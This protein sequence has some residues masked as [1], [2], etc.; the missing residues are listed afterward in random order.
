MNRGPTGVGPR[1]LQVVY[2]AR[3]RASG[4]TDR[5]T[6]RM[7]RLRRHPFT[8]L[9]PVACDFFAV[10]DGRTLQVHAVLPDL[11]V[12]PEHRA[13]LLFASQRGATTHPA[14]I[15]RDA[16]GG[17]A[18]E[19]MAPLGHDPGELPLTSG[20]WTV[21]VR[22]SAPGGPERRFALRI[23]EPVE[24]TGPTVATPPHPVSG[25]HYRPA[26]SAR[27][28]A[29]LTVTGPPARAEVTRLATDHTGARIRARL[30]GVGSTG[31]HPTVVFSPRRGGADVVL[32]VHPVNG[33]FELLVPLTRLATGGPG[34]EI[35]WEVWVRPSTTRMIRVGRY[36]HDLRNPQPILSASREILPLGDDQFAGYRPYY[37]AAGN[38]AVACLR[39]TRFTGMPS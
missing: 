15:R 4:A 17:L 39:F 28:T 23:A 18:V 7:A 11:P 25:H 3:R 12:G 8:G 36:L 34:E 13:E 1:L 21:A 9:P 5:I 37:T 29:Q 31:E 27:G 6:R 26:R 32:P 22:I 19:A 16:A 14:T 30:V 24:P 10:P 38:L 20:T 33:E 2:G 35:I